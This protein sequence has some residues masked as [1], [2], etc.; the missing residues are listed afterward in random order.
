MATPIN[1]TEEHGRIAR[2]SKYGQLIVSPIDYSTPSFKRIDAPD[3]AFSFIAPATA[4]SI[5]IT[6]IIFSTDR[7]SPVAGS[8][9]EIYQADSATTTASIKDIMV[10]DL[11]RQSRSISTG[12]NMFVPGGRWVNAKSSGVDVLM[13]IMFYRVPMVE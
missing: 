8:L 2:V 7:S 3:T 12:L 4:Q 10:D 11:E 13:T 9:V 5:V 1:I 6:D